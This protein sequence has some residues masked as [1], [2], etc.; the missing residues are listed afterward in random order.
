MAPRRGSET[1][2]RR[3]QDGMTLRRVGLRSRRWAS[4]TGFGGI[5]GDDKVW[6]WTARGAGRNG[7]AAMENLGSLTVSR[8]RKCATRLQIFRGSRR[9]GIYSRHL[10]KQVAKILYRPIAPGFKNKTRYA[11]YVS[12]GS[13]ISHI[14]TNKGNIIRQCLLHSVLVQR[15]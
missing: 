1:G 11:P 3:G 14:A 12:P 9:A 8:G 10:Y 4:E 2:L 15:I 6:G 5:G 7:A 13:Q